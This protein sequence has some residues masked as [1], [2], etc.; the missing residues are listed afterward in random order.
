MRDT[1]DTRDDKNVMYTEEIKDTKDIKIPTASG[2][3]MLLLTISGRPC[4]LG[5]TRLLGI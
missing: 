2:L 4:M 5:M 3:P 1:K